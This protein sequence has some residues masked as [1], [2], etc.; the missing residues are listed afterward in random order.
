MVSKI[1]NTAA[2]ES[3][4]STN[5]AFQSAGDTPKTNTASMSLHGQLLPGSAA[6]ACLA[7][8]VSFTPGKEQ[9]GTRTSA[10]AG[11]KTTGLD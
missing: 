7:P 4:S 8:G 9:A 3:F 2:G 11:L 5:S 10:Q 1:E 6:P